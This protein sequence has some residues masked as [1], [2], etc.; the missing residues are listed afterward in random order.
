MLSFNVHVTIT[1][2]VIITIGDNVIFF[3]GIIIKFLII[4]IALL[5]IMM[6]DVVR[7]FGVMVSSFSFLP[8]LSEQLH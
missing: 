5:I 4:F 6:V 3:D 1:I 2:T 7:G 8:I